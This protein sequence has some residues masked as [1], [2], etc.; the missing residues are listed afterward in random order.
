ME[1][2][3]Q[4]ALG[5]ELGHPAEQPAAFLAD[6]F[7]DLLVLD[8]LFEF[9]E[10]FRHLGG[11]G[12]VVGDD[13]MIR[14]PA[15]ADRRLFLL[16]LGLAILPGQ[17]GQLLGQVFGQLIDDNDAV[18]FLPLG[19]CG[20]LESVGHD[21]GEDAVLVEIQRW[22]QAISGDVN[23]PAGDGGVVLS[24]IIAEKFLVRRRAERRLGN[25]GPWW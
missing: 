22:R 17:F 21:P 2:G 4:I 11:D 6:L 10:L 12:G 20:T 15:E 5:L 19:V 18:G 7:G 24:A 14:P 8:E 9:V 3:P 23:G 16:L 1:R 13:E 25:G